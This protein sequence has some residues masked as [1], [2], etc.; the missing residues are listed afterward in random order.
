[1]PQGKLTG[2]AAALVPRGD[3]YAPRVAADELRKGGRLKA[4][5]SE[6]ARAK[7]NQNFVDALPTMTRNVEMITAGRLIS[8]GSMLRCVCR[9][10]VLVTTLLPAARATLLLALSRTV[11]V[12]DWRT[13]A[14]G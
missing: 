2:K 9:A 13:V 4:A 5:K 10:A 14:L 8:Q 3:R 12:Q 1:M 7:I 11:A 6:F